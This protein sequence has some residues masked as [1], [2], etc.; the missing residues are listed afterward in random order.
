MGSYSPTCLWSATREGSVPLVPQVLRE[1]AV[2]GQDEF[3]FGADPFENAFGQLAGPVQWPS[4]TETE[5]LQTFGDLRE[6][7]EQLVD[8]F[9]FEIRV[10]P[11]C[12]QTNSWFSSGSPPRRTTGLSGSAAQATARREFGQHATSG[13]EQPV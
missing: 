10:I 6:W 7:V 9:A 12:C 5:R 4:L 1:E 8:R 2:G 13:V 11:P 3:G